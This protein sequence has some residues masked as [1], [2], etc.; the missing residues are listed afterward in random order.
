MHR[1]VVRMSDPTEEFFDQLG[2]HGHER[3]LKKTTGSI[4]FDIDHDG[5]TDHWLVAITNGAVRVSREDRGADTVLH[6]EKVFFER[7][8][9]GGVHPLAAWLRSDI[10]CEGRFRFLVLLERL[11]PPPPAARHPRAFAREHGWRK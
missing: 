5:G 1:T 7:M 10:V 8:A 9:R 3:L 11:F 4:R 6:I 2:R